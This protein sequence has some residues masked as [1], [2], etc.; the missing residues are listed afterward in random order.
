[1]VIVVVYNIL[2]AKSRRLPVKYTVIYSTLWTPE[3]GQHLRPKYVVV[4]YV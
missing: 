4:L 2:W 1:M 3:D